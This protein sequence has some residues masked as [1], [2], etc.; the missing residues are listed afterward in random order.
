[1]IVPVNYRMLVPINPRV[2]STHS[3]PLYVVFPLRLSR[4]G[5][6]KRGPSSGWH[7]IT[8]RVQAMSVMQLTRPFLFSNRSSLLEDPGQ[9][10]V[11]ILLRCLSRNSPCPRRAAIRCPQCDLRCYD[12]GFELSLCITWSLKPE[13]YR[14]AYCKSWD[15]WE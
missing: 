7:D 6:R 8:P 9:T 12:N 15:A 5:A 10:A 14:A 1:M 4:N 13:R 2:V 3:S 11:Q